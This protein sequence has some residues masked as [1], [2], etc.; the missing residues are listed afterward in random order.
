MG[1]LPGAEKRCALD[2]KV[3]EETDCGG[4]VRRLITYQ[5]EPRGACPPTYASQGGAEFTPEFSRCALPP[6]DQ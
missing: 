2:V 5:A 1:P 6:R 4:Y 3:L